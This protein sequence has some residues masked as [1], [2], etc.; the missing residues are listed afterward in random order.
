[1]IVVGRGI[2]DD[3]RSSGVVIIAQGCLACDISLGIM[4][5][6][7]A[8]FHGTLILCR[9]SPHGPLRV[10]YQEEV[11]SRLICISSYPTGQCSIGNNPG[12]CSS[13]CCAGQTSVL[14]QLWD[15]KAVAYLL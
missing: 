9:Q 13:H 12:C 4:A 6:T 8:G 15:G 10:G 2:C 11:Q 7:F 1:M 14:V 3:L 5:L